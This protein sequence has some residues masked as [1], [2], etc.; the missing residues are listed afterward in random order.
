MARMNQSIS[1]CPASSATSTTGEALRGLRDAVPVMIGFVPL[2]LVLG[3]QAAKKGLSLFDVPLMTASNFA[4]GSEFSAVALWA[5]PI[6]VALIVAVTFLINSRHLIMGAALTPAVCHLPRRKVLPALFFMCDETWAL[7][8]ADARK[9]T[10]QRGDA[11]VSLGYY[12]GVSA[13]LYVAWVGFSALGTLAAPYV[14]DVEAWGF[15]MAFP[16]VFLVLLR[17]MWKG[18]RASRPWFAS[19][20]VAAGT[21]LLVPGA[22]YVVAGALVGL[23]TAALWSGD[24]D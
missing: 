12:Y 18:F 20:V 6:P 23:G 13:G 16:A 21:H 24:H 8:L 17:G 11:M 15:Q 19:L 3:A 10:G 2:A 5:H 1:S 4:G 14:A 22:W 9:R 7:S